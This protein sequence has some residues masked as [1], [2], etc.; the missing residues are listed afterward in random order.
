MAKSSAGSTP[1]QLL[2]PG[3]TLE[4]NYYTYFFSDIISQLEITPLLNKD[5]W[6]RTVLVPSQQ[7]QCVRHAV[8][9]L[10]ATHWQYAAPNQAPPASL[11]RFIL[12]HYN[13][14]ISKLTGDQGSPPDMPT[15][16]TCCILFVL[17]ESLR[18]DFDEAVRH[19]ESGIRILANHAPKTYL[20]NRDYQEL[21]TLFHA[22]S[23]QVAIFAQDR[24]F[25]DVT[26]LLMPTKKQKRLEGEFRNLD[27]AEDVMNKFDDMV[28][29]ISWDL[30]Q[31]WEDENSECNTQWQILSENI[32]TWQC[33]FEMLVS[34]LIKSQK[35]EL[36]DWEKILNLRIQHKLW[37]LLI[38]EETDEHEGTQAQLDP[39]E[40][41]TLL[42]QL[43]QIWCNP[44]R[45]RFGLKID[46]IAAFFQLYVYCTDDTK[47]TMH[48]SNPLSVTMAILSYGVPAASCAA[49]RP[50]A[51]VY[52]G[53][54]SS[55]GC[56]EG[57]GQLLESS[58]SKFEVVY[59][60]PNE[61]IDVAEALKGAVV[62]AHGG[63]PN[64]RKAY[65]STKK[66]EKAIQEFVSSGGHY[67]GFC[68]GA[69]LAGPKNGYSLL[70]KGVDTYDE[71]ERHG[72]QVDNE[73]DTVIQIDWTFQSGTTEKKRWM[74]FQDGVV[75]RGMDDSKGKVIGRYSSN[76]DVAASITPYGKGW[77]GLVGPHP[78]ADESWYEDA[79]ITNPEGIRMDI[80]H[81]FVE[82]TIH[83]GKHS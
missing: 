45:P 52:R 79:E 31:Q 33:Q 47:I 41:N 46:L 48:L 14:A 11:D 61:P 37:E 23:S 35:R 15:V 50:K 83:A 54:A 78:E 20:P 74:Y 38:A 73:A 64:W 5:F 7:S 82:A 44:T 29:H 65:R 34:R 72:T 6:S 57:V 2:L 71:I 8:L 76:G 17:L 39:A 19:L 16:L 10:G 28:N 55:P 30:E 26:H 56:P 62:Y 67:L 80:G 49:P 77:V 43:E 40:C 69:Y 13:E 60:G 25:P 63:G 27:E 24:V 4:S 12:K 22:I 59:A 21:A 42:D 1:S 75:V 3:D 66:Y 18:G 36:I 32:Q 9:A 68:L 58:P 51:V 70:P 81:D 53:P